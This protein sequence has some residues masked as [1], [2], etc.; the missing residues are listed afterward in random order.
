MIVSLLITI[1]GIL[2]ALTGFGYDFYDDGRFL[3][4]S[5][6]ELS[7][8]FNADMDFLYF[9]F[10][11]IHFRF[12]FYYLLN[13]HH[14]PLISLIAYVWTGS[15]YEDIRNQSDYVPFFSIWGPFDLL[16]LILTFSFFA[17][18]FASYLLGEN[19]IVTLVVGAPI[20]FIYE[21]IPTLIGLGIV[22]GIIGFLLF[23]LLGKI[24]G[25]G[26]SPDFT[27]TNKE[28]SVKGTFNGADFNAKV[29][30]DK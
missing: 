11:L 3:V 4:K 23:A 21:V 26:P 24:L 20:F 1:L 13:S 29:R 8:Y 22:L 6:N 16:Y 30:E 19:S 2:F 5:V 7:R 10:A 9:S 18:P 27:K 17:Q 12:A 15:A 14:Y 25:F 28:Y